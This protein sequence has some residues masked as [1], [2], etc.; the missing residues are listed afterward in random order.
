M[1]L[2]GRWRDFQELEES[3]SLPELTAVLSSIREKEQREQKFQA[4]LQGV[5]L[6]AGSKEDAAMAFE[7]VKA[8]VLNGKQSLGVEEIV[9]HVEAGGDFKWV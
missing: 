2:L 3:L 7:R 6:D 9:D 1:F 5:D 4:A 8:E